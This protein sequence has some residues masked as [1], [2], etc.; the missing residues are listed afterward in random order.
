MDTTQAT[1]RS[2]ST[3]VPETAAD[4]GSR[5]PVDSLSP[6]TPDEEREAEIW[7]YAMD[8]IYRVGRHVAA[9]EEADRIATGLATFRAGEWAIKA[10]DAAAQFI[11]EFSGTYGEEGFRS[12]TAVYRMAKMESPKQ[13]LWMGA[14]K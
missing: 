14:W 13:S 2:H 4:S 11:M 6:L 5:P 12:L 9:L 10:H 7:S 3:S 8:H 1:S